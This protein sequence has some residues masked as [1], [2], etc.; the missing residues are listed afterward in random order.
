MKESIC[1]KCGRRW[2][3]TPLGDKSILLIPISKEVIKDCSECG[4][5]NKK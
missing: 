5:F 2:K 4:G 1:P 3:A